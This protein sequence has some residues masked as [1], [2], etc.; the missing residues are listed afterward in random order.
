MNDLYFLEFIVKSPAHASGYQ[1][2]GTKVQEG[3]PEG[4]GLGYAGQRP[5]TFTEDTT[6]EKGHRLVI[7]KASPSKP[8]S[9]HTQLQKMG[10][11]IEGWVHPLDR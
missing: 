1:C 7:I 11:R 5:F 10:G 9:G 4:R 6:L 8:V 2:L 3:N